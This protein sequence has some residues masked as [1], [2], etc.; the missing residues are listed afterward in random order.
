[1]SDSDE[2]KQPDFQKTL[3]SHDDQDGKPKPAPVYKTIEIDELAAFK[4]A[5]IAAA[6]RG[7][8]AAAR[9]SAPSKSRRPSSRSADFADTELTES[10]NAPGLSTTQYGDLN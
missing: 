10:H 8:P 9:S 2:H 1:V 5:R 4:E 6:K 7:P 3:E